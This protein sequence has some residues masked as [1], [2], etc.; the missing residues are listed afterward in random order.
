M[1]VGLTQKL[2]RLTTSKDFIPELD[3]LRFLAIFP[4]LVLHLDQMLRTSL[5]VRSTVAGFEGFWA[6]WGFGVPLFFAI[7]GFILCR[8]FILEAAAGGKR[9]QLSQYYLRRVTRLE[10]PYI[11]SLSLFFFVVLMA[12]GVRGGDALPHYLASLFYQ[13]NIIYGQVST[14]NA[15]AW[16]LEI[17][18]QFYLLVPFFCRLVWRTAPAI[19]RL[20][21]LICLAGL[22]Y[23]YIER[24]RLLASLHLDRSLLAFGHFFICGMLLADVYCAGAARFGRRSYWWDLLGVAAVMSWSPWWWRGCPW[25]LALIWNSM[26]IAGMFLGVFQ[27]PVLNRIFTYK[28]I[29]AIGGMCYTI[30]LLHNP[31]FHLTV[32]KAAW[33][34]IPNHYWINLAIQAAIQIPLLLVICIGYYLLIEKPCMDKQWPIRVWAW[35]RGRAAADATSSGTDCGGS[36]QLPEP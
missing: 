8:P 18:I 12:K 33:L 27:G 1:N 4:V 7:S 9:V 14:I 19:R 21:L 32:A 34:S 24:T 29:W 25:L 6:Q 36:S 28:W 30:Y 16:S 5:G 26:S 2:R 23:L 17:E 10:P 20:I 15:V 3:G 13:H 11:V 35:V 31:L 22:S